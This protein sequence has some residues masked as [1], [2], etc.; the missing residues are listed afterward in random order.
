MCKNFVEPD[1]PQMT[2]WRTRVACWIPEDRTH[3]QN[4][5]Y[6]SF[7]TAM[8]LPRT[9]FI[10]TSHIYCLSSWSKFCQLKKILAAAVGCWDSWPNYVRFIY[11]LT[12]LR[13]GFPWLL[14]AIYMLPMYIVHGCIKSL[15]FYFIVFNYPRRIWCLKAAA[16]DLVLLISEKKAIKAIASSKTEMKFVSVPLLWVIW[17]SIFHRQVL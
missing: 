10:V 1:R 11:E 14:E 12:W 6:L 16:T 7:S 5:K 13:C 3:T 4:T 8:V 17:V 9:H 15:R 2:I